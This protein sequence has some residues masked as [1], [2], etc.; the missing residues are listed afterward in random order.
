MQRS[1]LYEEKAAAVRFFLRERWKKMLGSEPESE[2]RP[3]IQHLKLFIIYPRERGEDSAESDG[4]RK[5]HPD[6]SALRQAESSLLLRSLDRLWGGRGVHQAGVFYSLRL[7]TVYQ[8]FASAKTHGLFHPSF[9]RIFRSFKS[10]RSYESRNFPKTMRYFFPYWST[11][12]RIRI[13]DPGWTTRIIFSRTWK[14][15]FFF[16]WG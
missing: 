1:P 5:G 13:R 7:Y 12:L 14:L 11:V 9:S 10:C 6:Q 2:G 8:D 15:F 16:F 4:R 3:W